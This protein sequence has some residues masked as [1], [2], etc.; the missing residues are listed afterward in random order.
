M[1]DEVAALPHVVLVTS[2]FSPEGAHLVSQDAT[3]AFATVIFDAQSQDLPK[4]AVEKVISTAQ[5]AGDEQ[6]QVAL[7]GQDIEQAENQGSSSSTGAGIFFA[8]VVLGVAFGALFAAFLPLITALIAIGIG[9]SLTGLLQPRL[10]RGQ[11][12]HHP[13][14]PHWPRRGRRLCPVH[15]HP[16][17]QRHQ[18]R[19]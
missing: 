18:G 1:L 5:A 4:E 9:Y 14:G 8:L 11:L 16:A 2:P 12:R 10:L 3:V 15:R 7:G 17:P 6:L 19:P 13:G